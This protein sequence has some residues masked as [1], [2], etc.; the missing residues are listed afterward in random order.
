MIVTPLSFADW[1]DVYYCQM[2]NHQKITL[3][4][5]KKNHKLENF[6]FKLDENKAAMVFGKRGYFATVVVKLRPNS[7]LPQREWWYADSDFGHYYFEDGKFLFSLVGS[8]GMSSVSA[9]CDKF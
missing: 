7:Q 1:G 5:E 2:T 3:S 9:D 8:T 4:G 6:L